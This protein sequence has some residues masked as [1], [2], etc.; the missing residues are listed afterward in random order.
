MT[1][2]LQKALVQND[3]KAKNQN[4]ISDYNSHSVLGK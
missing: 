3:Q 2:C 4:T 1:S